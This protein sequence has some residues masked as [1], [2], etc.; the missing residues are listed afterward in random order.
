MQQLLQCIQC[1]NAC[2]DDSPEG[3]HHVDAASWALAVAVFFACVVESVEATT[4][5]MAMGFT[6]SWRSALIGTGTALVA[7]ALFTWAAGYALSTWLPEA[8]LQLVIGT[9]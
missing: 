8:A 1:F 2:R 4:I 6:R 7:L 5:V 9:L 3:G